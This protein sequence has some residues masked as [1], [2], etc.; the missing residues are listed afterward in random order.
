V[1]VDIDVKGGTTFANS[2]EPYKI[3][4]DDQSS[5]SSPLTNGLHKITVEDVKDCKLEK[6]VILSFYKEENIDADNT[7]QNLNK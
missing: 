5:F 7:A 3:K 6:E 1:L 4:I 2:E